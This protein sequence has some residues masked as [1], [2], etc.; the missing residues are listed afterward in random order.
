LVRTLAV[1]EAAL[2][3]LVLMTVGTVA[4]LL[5]AG[6]FA[7]LAGVAAIFVLNPNVRSCGCFGDDTPATWAHVVADAVACAVA[8]AAAAASPASLPATVRALGWGSVA[9]LAG[10]C[11]IAYLAHAA[12]TLLPG[13]LSAYRGDRDHAHA[14]ADRAGGRHRHART[15]DALRAEGV[16][17]GHPSLWGE[18]MAGSPAR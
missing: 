18:R 16:A 8:L 12:T 6:A 4:C 10:V 9:F 7:A 14:H 1:A 3:S 17:E 11:C 5:L 2:G 13:A 15:E